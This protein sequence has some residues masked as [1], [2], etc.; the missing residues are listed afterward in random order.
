[1]DNIYE[2][3]ALQSYL[4]DI[5]RYSALSREEEKEIAIKAKAGDLSAKEAL[6]KSNLK[7]VVKIA[8]KYQNRGL[9]LSELISDGNLGLI[10]AIEKFDPEKDIKLISYAVWWIKQ[11]ILYAIVKRNE[12]RVET[13]EFGPTSDMQRETEVYYEQIESTDPN[14][15][16]SK[17]RLHKCIKR[18]IE[19]LNAR[20]AFVIKSYFG[21]YGFEEMTYS[22][23]AEL[24]GISREAVRQLKIKSMEK[25]L[26][27]VNNEKESEINHILSNIYT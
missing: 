24:L 23:I 21:L 20:E 26:K 11:K 25:I 3:K 13:R 8:S 5:S 10:T 18:A 7:F 1:M 6:I 27:K 4:C 9:S 15:I 14:V 17:E 12:S 22:K 16:F 2:D 19:E